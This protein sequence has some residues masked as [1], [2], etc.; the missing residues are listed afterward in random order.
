M[1]ARIGAATSVSASPLG[2]L[3]A[4]CFSTESRLNAEAVC[5]SIDKVGQG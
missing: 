5:D 2:D 1:L 3:A 4:I